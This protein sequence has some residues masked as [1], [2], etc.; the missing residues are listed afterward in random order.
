MKLE[1]QIATKIAHQEGHERRFSTLC[2]LL[3]SSN[4]WGSYPPLATMCFSSV[5]QALSKSKGWRIV[6]VNVMGRND[7][8]WRNYQHSRQS[9]RA[10]HDSPNSYD[11][12]VDSSIDQKPYAH[13][14]RNKKKRNTAAGTNSPTTLNPRPVTVHSTTHTMQI[15]ICTILWQH[16]PL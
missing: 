9:Q 14:D 5:S 11:L 4:S 10:Q 7:S 2:S 1:S 12:R 8:A 15:N 6:G 3:I 16:F 13:S